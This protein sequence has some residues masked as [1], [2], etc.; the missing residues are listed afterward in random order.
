[1]KYQIEVVKQEFKITSKSGR[2]I[3]LAVDENEFFI[4]SVKSNGKFIF[5]NKKTDKV[6]NLWADVIGLMQEAVRVAGNLAKTD[7]CDQIIKA[8]KKLNKKK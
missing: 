4:S 7:T 8:N 6:I 3:T 5:K 1:M 2:S